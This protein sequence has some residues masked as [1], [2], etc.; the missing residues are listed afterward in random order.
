MYQLSMTW[1]PNEV[2]W[3]GLRCAKALVPGGVRGASKKLNTPIMD[4][5]ANIDGLCPDA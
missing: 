5:W 3:S 1:T 2:C 4:V